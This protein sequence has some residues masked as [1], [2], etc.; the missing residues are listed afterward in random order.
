MFLFLMLLFFMSTFEALFK[1]VKLLEFKLLDSSNLTNLNGAQQPS[2]RSN[3]PRWQV[4]R[5]A[6]RRSILCRKICR[7]SMLV[8]T[9]PILTCLLTRGF[10]DGHVEQP[11]R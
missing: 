8:H 3:L 10:A 11:G 5:D 6:S 2:V 7:G 4:D 1:L 9:W